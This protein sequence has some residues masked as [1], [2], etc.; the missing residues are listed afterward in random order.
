MMISLE[1][2]QG[3]PPV[4]VHHCDAARREPGYMVVS[5]GKGARAFSGSSDYEVL[6]AL[7]QNGK[8]EW[9]WESERSL[10]DVKL[11]SNKT[12]LVLTTDGC[13]QEINFDG[14]TLRK[15]FTRCDSRR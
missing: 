8:G 13:I 6:F 3:F 2:P 1:L 10:L 14:I 4:V 12:L 9:Y 5:A 15:W 11:T 7:D